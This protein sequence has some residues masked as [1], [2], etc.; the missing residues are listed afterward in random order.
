MRKGNELIALYEATSSKMDA[1]GNSQKKWG[2]A[3]LLVGI[4]AVFAAFL[5]LYL[6][7]Y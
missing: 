7:N 4:L 2:S 6:I 5:L 1:Q 3:V